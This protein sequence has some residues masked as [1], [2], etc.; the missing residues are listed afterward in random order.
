[1]NS[2]AGSILEGLVFKIADGPDIERALRLRRDVY[3]KDWSHVGPAL[4]VDDLDRRAH[5]LIAEDAEGDIVATLRIVAS[6]HRP[7]DLERYVALSQIFDDDRNP[8]EV[9]RL[10]I[11]HS[12]RRV[13]SGA[14]V[15][16]GMLKLA[17]AFARK[18]CLTDLVLTAIPR[19]QNFYRIGFFEAVGIR[20]EHP[21]WGPV[22]VMRLDLV[23]LDEKLKKAHQP[24]ARLLLASE[25]PRIAI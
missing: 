10:C 12:K 2:R 17:Y 1:M 7:F 19:L 23:Q 4:V 18:A 21:T 13:R 20:F 24:M 6:A 5:H 3:A 8:G 11:S 9:G 16:L 14:F 25:W 15:H 22:H